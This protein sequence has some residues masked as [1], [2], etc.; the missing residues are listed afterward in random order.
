[1]TARRGQVRVVEAVLAVF[2]V[3]AV[4]LL[5]MQFTRPL[6][7]VYIRET[8][9]L[10]RLGYNLLNS[11]A[12]N[13]VYEKVLGDLIYEANQRFSASGKCPEG[14]E[15]NRL[16]DLAFFAST[17]L[18]QGLLFRMDVYTVHYDLAGGRAV[19]CP[20]G[21]A[22]NFDVDKVSMTEAEPIIYTYV[23][24]GDPDRVRG[25]ALLVH[26]TIGYSG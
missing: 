22:A 9:D 1:V 24:T 19:L 25:S 3:V 2:M 12:E 15:G 6:R 26:L 4:I 18:P 23:C 17:V 10:R 8:S 21:Y 5:L 20:L 14:W 11:M 16:D 13:N 7:S